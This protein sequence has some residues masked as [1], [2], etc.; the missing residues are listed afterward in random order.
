MLVCRGGG[1]EHGVVSNPIQEQFG[2]RVIQAFTD[3]ARADLKPPDELEADEF[4]HV[5]DAGMRRCMAQVLYGARWLYKL[6]LATLT[7][8]EERAA[9]VRAQLVD[10][11]SVIEGLLSDM[12]AHAIR[13]GHAKGTA[14]QWNDPDVKKRP[15]TWTTSAPE[16]V[17]KKATFWWLIRVAREFGIVSRT[18]ADDLNKL[19]GQRN[20]V[21]IRQMATLGPGAFLNQ[22]KQAY[23]LVTQTLRATQ[24]WRVNHA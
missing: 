3:F 19:R 17:L 18:L 1:A 21:H 5:G 14:Y 2:E 15:I 12:I 9:H 16:A 24:R 11:S 20:D 4:A 22:S 8:G 7:H 23:G 10:Y 6:G 13:K